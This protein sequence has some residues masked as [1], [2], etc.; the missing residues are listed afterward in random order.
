MSTPL[1]TVLMPAYNA[2]KYINEAVSSVLNQTFTDFELL[3]INDGSTDS[4]KQIIELFTDTRIRLINQTNQGVAAALNIG[5]LNAKAELIARFD[6][7]DICVPERLGIQYEYL[8]SNTDCILVGANADYIDMHGEF[9]FTG[10]MLAYT[11]EDIRSSI[12]NYCPLI[13]SAIMFRKEP[14]FKAGC[15]NMH[16]HTFEDHFLWVKLLQYGKA[17]NLATSLIKV[18]LVPESVSVDE[19]WRTKEFQ[20]IKTDSI[21]RGYITEETGKKLDGIIKKQNNHRVKQGSYYALLGKKYL[22]DNY[23]P[24]KARINLRKAISIA[25]AR[26]DSYAIMMLSFFPKSFINWLYTK[27]LEKI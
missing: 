25:P 10:R 8:M 11:N 23:Q 1:I 15:Y 14:V 19:K 6:A 9:V 13:H 12:T 18:R 7:D 27:R 16:A 5:L 24:T 3:I 4:T 21:N 22:W 2:E 20:Q 26:L 17:F